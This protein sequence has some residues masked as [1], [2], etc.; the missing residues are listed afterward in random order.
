MRMK[1]D[2]QNEGRLSPPPAEVSRSDGG[3]KRVIC[4][5]TNNC[6]YNKKL[7]PL[8]SS[9]RHSMTKAE[10]CL[11]KFALKAKQLNGY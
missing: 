7:K 10:A 2:K 4:N 9:L 5:K 8:A 11:W 1:H 3:G 6:H